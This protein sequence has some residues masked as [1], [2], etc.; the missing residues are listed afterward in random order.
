[1][2]KKIIGI[3]LSC[4]ISVGVV[5]C[6][7]NSTEVVP[8]TKV[9]SEQDRIATLQG[10]EGEELIKAYEKLLTKD[11]LSFLKDCDDSINELAERYKKGINL[12]IGENLSG[13]E[14]EAERRIAEDLNK[15]SQEIVRDALS[16]IC[17][18]YWTNNS[19]NDI[20][21]LEIQIKKIDANGNTETS[22]GTAQNIRNGETRKL[23]FWVDEN[24]QSIEVTGVNIYHVPQI[25]S[26]DT[27][28]DGCIPGKWYYINE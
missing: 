22:Q 16:S 6:S 25:D 18:I 12:K 14:W 28:F 13:N 10:L 5:G 19:G 26:A 1:M 2:K 3:A 9:I 15:T 21:W 17:E 24:S 27:I 8:E 4:F 11:E 20:Q 23:K 7:S